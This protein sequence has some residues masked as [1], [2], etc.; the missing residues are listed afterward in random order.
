MANAGKD[1]NGSQVGSMSLLRLTRQF[2]ICTVKTSWLDNRHVVFGNVIEG[3]D[4][5]HQI[6]NVAK[7]GSDKPKED[8]K[9]VASGEVGQVAL[10]SLTR[11]LE[12]EEEVDA[13]G[14]KVPLRI[15]L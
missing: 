7:G 4:I 6:E 10:A 3:M 11:Q 1:T 15:E 12:I 5:V 8:V 2:F 13:E 14:N 9:I